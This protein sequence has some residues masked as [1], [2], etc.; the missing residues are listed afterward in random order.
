[1]KNYY[2]LYVIFTGKISNTK[3]VEMYQQ[4]EVFVLPS[5]QEGFPTVAAEAQACGKPVIATNISSIPEVIKHNVTGILVPANNPQELA[6]A[7]ITV[8]SNND[9][10]INLSKNAREHVIKNFSKE[11]RKEKITKLL[12]QTLSAKIF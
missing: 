9:L 11:L 7:I 10:K 8:L 1:M 12:K 5:R 4:C 2:G 6:N 3:L